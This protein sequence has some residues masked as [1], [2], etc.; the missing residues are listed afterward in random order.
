M[1]NN[2][3]KVYGYIRVSTETQA[4]KGYGLDTQTSAIIKY[5]E[6]NSLQLVRI[7]SDEGISGTMGDSEDLSKR[8]G[9]C[10][11]LDVLDKGDTIIVMNKSRLWRDDSAKV[12]LSR[13]VRSLEGSIVSIEEPRYSL[14]SKD[15]SE[16]LFNSMMEMLDTYSRLEINM[17]LAK[18]RNTKAK[19]GIKACGITP[20]GYEYSADKKSIIVNAKEANFIK[21]LFELSLSFIKVDESNGNN[22]IRYG[23]LADEIN[24]RGYTTR[25]GNEWSSPAIFKILHNDFYI[26]ILTH[27]DKVQG[28]HIPIIDMEVWNKIHHVK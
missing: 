21:E 3:S 16:F 14:Y 11:M 18:G 20:Y 13:K 7:F 10:D 24:G 2:N 6:D 9:I 12:Y 5:C 19:K 22:V 23:K 4:D 28:S 25:K 17:K 1:L 15:P 26:G 27:I 8:K